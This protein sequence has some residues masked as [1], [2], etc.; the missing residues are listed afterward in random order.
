MADVLPWQL[1]QRWADSVGPLPERVSIGGRP[2]PLLVRGLVLVRYR[3]QV[4]ESLAAWDDGDHTG[5]LL[6]PHNWQTAAYPFSVVRLE[7]WLAD[8]F[9]GGVYEL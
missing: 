4:W 5:F 2:S 1:V 3:G 8:R 9:N 6:M 7:S